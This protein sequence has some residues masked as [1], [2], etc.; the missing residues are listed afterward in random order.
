M[1]P[2]PCP[3]PQIFVKSS[4]SNLICS[5]RI[6]RR[7]G[8]HFLCHSSANHNFGAY[9]SRSF[10]TCCLLTALR[11]FG[12]SLKRLSSV[13]LFF[14]LSGQWHANGKCGWRQRETCHFERVVGQTETKNHLT[15]S[16][17]SCQGRTISPAHLSKRKCCVMAYLISTPKNGML[18]W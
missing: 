16:L 12:V 11:S 17:R 1:C 2:I 8:L 5:W 10:D 6:R 7:Q 13:T 3:N 4:I 15:P 18:L 9:I 14:I